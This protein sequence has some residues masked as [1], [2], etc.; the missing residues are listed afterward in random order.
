[1]LLKAHVWQRSHVE[2][3]EFWRFTVSARQR[4][5]RRERDRKPGACWCV[6]LPWRGER[7]AGVHSWEYGGLWCSALA[8]VTS[9]VPERL[10]FCDLEEWVIR[11]SSMV[12]A[13]G[14]VRLDL[15]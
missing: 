10:F 8:A 4:A 13:G 2:L 3:H 15:V 1:M 11:Q 9:S 12:A 7:A 14:S 6:C 5:E